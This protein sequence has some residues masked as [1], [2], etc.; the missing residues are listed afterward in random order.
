MPLPKDL[1]GRCLSNI[2]FKYAIALAQ[3]CRVDVLF[4]PAR[5]SAGE[6]KAECCFADPYWYICACTCFLIA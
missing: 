2:S 1:V 6:M 3:L 4:H 5:T